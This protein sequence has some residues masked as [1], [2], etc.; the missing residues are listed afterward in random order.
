[1]CGVL[2]RVHLR[3][4]HLQQAL[5]ACAGAV[6]LLRRAPKSGCVLS[7][8]G[9]QRSLLKVQQFVLVGLVGSGIERGQRRRSTSSSST[10]WQPVDRILE[11]SLLEV[12]TDAT[13]SPSAACADQTGHAGGLAAFPYRRIFHPHVSVGDLALAARIPVL[14]TTNSRAPACRSAKS[15][16]HYLLS[17]INC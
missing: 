3:V 10:T 12:S 6:A 16:R 13:P 2:Y 5:R 14:S 11:L 15:V 17:R 8:L 9:Q 1:M 4:A 7:G